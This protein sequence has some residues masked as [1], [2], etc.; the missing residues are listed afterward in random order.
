MLHL[1]IR[2]LNYRV[3]L[4]GI[5]DS[6]C[7]FLIDQAPKDKTKLVRKRMIF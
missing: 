1:P 5:S 6:N 2:N 4:N 3:Y 7:L